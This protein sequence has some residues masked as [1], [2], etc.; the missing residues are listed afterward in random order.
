MNTPLARSVCRLARLAVLLAAILS[1]AGLSAAGPAIAAKAAPEA[2]PLSLVPADV[3]GVGGI[4]LRQLS[5]AGAISAAVDFLDAISS[6]EAQVSRMMREV[7]LDPSRD[8]RKAAIIVGK[9]EQNGDLGP[10]PKAVIV[11][12]QFDTEAI[13]KFAR[14]QSGGR[15]RETTVGGVKMLQS[16]TSLTGVINGT[17][18]VTG[19]NE[20]VEQIIEVHA[21]SAKPLPRN[22]PL[23]KLAKEHRNRSFWLVSDVHALPES[24]RRLAIMASTGLDASKLDHLIAWADVSRDGTDFRTEIKC[25]DPETAQ[26][27]KTWLQLMTNMA[28]G[29]GQIIT[30]ERPRDRDTI[31]RVAR[32]VKTGASES[33]AYI[34]AEV[35][36]RLL[37]RLR[38]A[39]LGLGADT[40]RVNTTRPRI[41]R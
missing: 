17:I 21:G 26:Q 16:D 3:A 32:R 25:A 41:L 23:L 37:A 34:E 29:M 11:A 38:S 27:M 13:F 33:T 4:D 14:E 40:E 24:K 9:T 36:S 10:V 7:N 12:G 39:V 18:L 31:D 5:E 6:P 8:L 15:L 30:S 19:T 2:D 20:L 35:S 22:S 28:V 1:A